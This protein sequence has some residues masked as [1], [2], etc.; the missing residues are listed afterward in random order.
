[1]RDGVWT[2]KQ[3]DI[4]LQLVKHMNHHIQQDK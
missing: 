3:K 4:I 1:M 2:K